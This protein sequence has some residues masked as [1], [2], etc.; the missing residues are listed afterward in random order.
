MAPPGAAG[1][2][3]D[4]WATAGGAVTTSVAE[5]F[6]LDVGS[7]VGGLVGSAV[8]AAVAGTGVGAV[9]GTAVGT[10]VGGR[11]VAG[12]GVGVAGTGGGVAGARTR[13]VPVIAPWIAQRYSNVPAAFIGSVRLWPSEST[14]VSKAPAD[15]AVCWAGSRLVQV[16]VSPTI[17]VTAGGRKRKPSMATAAEAAW[18]V[19]PARRRRRW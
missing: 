9:V 7:T 19:P 18:V 11:V 3:G 14:P 2:E 12:T 16:T 1:G 8:G 13:T 15:V 17:T 10:A 5:A 6:A 4:C